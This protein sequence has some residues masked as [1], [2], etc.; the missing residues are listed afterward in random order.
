M[1]YANRLEVDLRKIKH[2]IQILKEDNKKFFAVVK[3]DAYGL[4]AIEVSK[5]IEDDIDIFCVAN[6]EEAIELRENGIKKD[7]LVLG[8]IHPKNYLY[9]EKYNLIV[10]IYNYDIAKELNDISNI[11]AHIKLETGHNRLGFQTDELFYNNSLVEIKKINQFE[12]INIEGI[13][14]HFS[15]ADENDTN[16][17]LM[18][19]KLFWNMIRDLHKISENWIKHLSNDAASIAYNIKSDAIRSGISMYGYFPS[20]YIRNNYNI[21]LRKSFRWIAKISNIKYVQKGESISYN[22]TF[23]A[24]KDIKVATVSCGYADGYKRLLSNKGYVQVNGKRANI[25]GNIT[26]DQ[27]M[28]DIS[29][30][31]VK[32]HDDVILIGNSDDEMIG[33]DIIGEWA[34]TISYEIMTS[35]SKRVK[36]IYVK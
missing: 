1:E 4:G 8:Y 22:R 11:R 19:E 34:E 18:Q 10:T 12:N 32:L 31:E 20:N 35:I 13:Y 2:N 6:I 36:R 3:A 26:M 16:Y 29:E 27:F 33:A 5:Y 15:S 24:D 17:T 21:D 14:T 28:I 7:I 9:I 30:I 25:L 23:I